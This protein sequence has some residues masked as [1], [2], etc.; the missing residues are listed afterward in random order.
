MGMKVSPPSA[1]R[2]F[3]ALTK[4]ISAGVVGVVGAALMVSAPAE[5]AEST[6]AAAAQQSGRYFGTAIAAG[7]LGDSQ[8]TT[9]ANREFDMI[10]AEN[11]MKINA[12]E[13]NQ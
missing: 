4:I 5:A 12:T 13:P 6:L 10:T 7:K 9:I 8:Y 1:R 11:E 2:S 3:G